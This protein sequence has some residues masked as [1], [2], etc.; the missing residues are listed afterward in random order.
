[1]PM[2]RPELLKLDR[3]PESVGEAVKKANDRV[4]E[5]RELVGEVYGEESRVGLEVDMEVKV[6]QRGLYG[7]KVLASKVMSERLLLTTKSGGL[8]QS[9]G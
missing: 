7:V 2:L 4:V 3:H 9:S 6:I 1:M 8:P 5:L